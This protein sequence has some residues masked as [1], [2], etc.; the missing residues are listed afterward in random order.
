MISNLLPLLP[1]ADPI[2]KTHRKKAGLRLLSLKG[3]DHCSD[4]VCR[5]LTDSGYC[6]YDPPRQIF[7]VASDTD[8]RILELSNN[9]DIQVTT[10]SSSYFLIIS[11]FNLDFV[12]PTKMQRVPLQTKLSNDE[13]CFYSRKAKMQSKNA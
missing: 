6:Q 9:S 2:S 5:W 3:A 7:V 10:S 1:P 11:N 4:C 8:L 13:I 12:N